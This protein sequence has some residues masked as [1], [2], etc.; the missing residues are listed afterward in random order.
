MAEPNSNQENSDWVDLDGNN[1]AIKQDEG[2]TQEHHQICEQA[3]RKQAANAKKNGKSA[4]TEYNNKLRCIQ[5]EQKVNSETIADIPIHKSPQRKH[6]TSGS[7]LLAWSIGSYVRVSPDTSPGK[8]SQGGE[9]F[10]VAMDKVGRDTF[11]SVKYEEY[12]ATQI[13]HSIPI[14]HITPSIL[15]TYQSQLQHSNRRSKRNNNNNE[16][17]VEN[18]ESKKRTY[19]SL[20]DKL[21]DASKMKKK[22]DGE[23]LNW[24]LRAVEIETV[25]LE[26]L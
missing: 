12:C 26:L 2:M 19:N 3:A 20:V 17:F 10:V 1:V 22:K 23:R 9:G 24:V 25:T 18:N 16:T 14:C 8:K 15:P 4:E 6:N 21:Q 11:L 5:Y 13:E 7:N